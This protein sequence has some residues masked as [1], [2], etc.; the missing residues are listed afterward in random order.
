MFD[1]VGLLT[2]KADGEGGGWEECAEGVG[3]SKWLNLINTSIATEQCREG[4]EAE[5]KSP[6]VC[7]G[8]NKV[9]INIL[10]CI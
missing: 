9:H 8:I 5:I 7:L 2:A 1:L 6:F 10:L 3:E 4:K